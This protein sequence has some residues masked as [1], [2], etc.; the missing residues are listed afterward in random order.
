MCT[1]FTCIYIVNIAKYIFSVARI[2]S[3]RNFNFNVVF[4]AR[5]INWLNHNRRPCFVQKLDKT[6]QAFFWMIGFAVMIARFIKFAAL[7]NHCERQT[8]VQKRQFTH[9]MSKRGVVVSEF[10][11]NLGV[12]F[13]RN[14]RTCSVRITDS[15]NISK[16]FSFWKFLDKH[17]AFTVN[18]CTEINRQS[19]NTRH[20]HTMQTT[21]HFIGRFVEFTACVKHC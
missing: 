9:P 6:F 5:Y 10:L 11:K 21:R 19:V 2:V 1:S 16:R 4:S 8:F 15:F 3:E 20:T 17:L 12:R 13:E 14:C 7:V 18:F